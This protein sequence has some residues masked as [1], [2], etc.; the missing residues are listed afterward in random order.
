MGEL[1]VK[2]SV[3]APSI[4]N[5]TQQ[6]DNVSSSLKR[7]FYKVIKLQIQSIRIKT[8]NLCWMA[9]RVHFI[10]VAVYYNDIKALR[11]AQCLKT[12]TFSN[13]KAL[14]NICKL[15][16]GFK[17]RLFIIQTSLPFPQY[18]KSHLKHPIRAPYYVCQAT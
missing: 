6:K 14:I 10:P 4:Q 15:K 8:I 9:L 17:L 5:Y 11:V 1:F 7:R 2:F 18:P 13:Q 12:C 16:L 3:S